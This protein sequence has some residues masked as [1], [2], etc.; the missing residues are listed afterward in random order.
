[1]GG[2]GAKGVRLDSALRE[3]KPDDD[4]SKQVHCQEVELLPF[5]CHPGLLVWV[6]VLVFLSPWLL[7]LQLNP[8]RQ[9]SVP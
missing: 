2:E 6:L 1:M 9:G 7:P 3:K 4:K 5:T 8:G